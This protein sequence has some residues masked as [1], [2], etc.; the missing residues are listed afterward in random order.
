MNAKALLLIALLATARVEAQCTTN[1]TLF[2]LTTN[3]SLAVTNGQVAKIVSAGFVG[4]AWVQINIG[5]N[6]ISLPAFQYGSVTNMPLP[7]IVAGPAFVSVIPTSGYAFCT[8]AIDTPCGSFTPRTAVVIPA[9]S[10]GPVNIILESSTDLITWNS[11]LPGT[12]GTSTTNRFFRVRAQRA[13]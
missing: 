13:P 3:V 11:A 7:L 2:G 12:Y 8:V 5:T 1:V 4:S 6:L 10:G 9:D